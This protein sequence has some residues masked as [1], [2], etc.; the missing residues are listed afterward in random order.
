[1]PLLARM[2][3]ES[4][5]NDKVVLSVGAEA[6]FVRAGELLTLVGPLRGLVGALV[7]Q[8]SPAGERPAPPSD[9][10]AQAAPAGPLRTASVMSALQ[11][12]LPAGA[13]VVVDAGNTGACAVHHLAAPPD[14]RWLLAMGM[15]GMGYAFGAAVG[16]SLA[17]GRRCV[18]VAGDGAFFMHGLEIHTALEHALPITYLLLNNRAHGMCLVRERLLLRDDGGYNSFGPSHLGAGLSAMFPGLPAWDCADVAA[19]ESALVRAFAHPGPSVV[20]VD[21]PEVEVPPFVAF[22]QAGARK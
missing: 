17:T 6:P 3:I 12:A 18:V 19:I 5:L 15:A 4:L 21:L 14:G 9:E 13:T 2:G 10:P 16:A 8:L 22:R 7:S 1:M 11:R 20:S